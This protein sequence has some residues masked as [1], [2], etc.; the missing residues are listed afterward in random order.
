[1]VKIF[2]DIDAVFSA[3][4]ESGT[5][6]SLYAGPDNDHVSALAAE[7]IA[8]EWRA[9]QCLFEAQNAENNPR[10]DE[11]TEKYFEETRKI[12]AFASAV[13]ANVAR[14]LSSG[15]FRRL[16]AFSAFYMLC[17]EPE[18]EML[19]AVCG[20]I[21]K[22]VRALAFDGGL[23]ANFGA[24]GADGFLAEKFPGYPPAS[25]ETVYRKGGELY[26]ET[27]DILWKK[28]E[29]VFAA[30]EAA[31]L[32]VF[33][34]CY[35]AIISMSDKLTVIYSSR[36]F[37]VTLKGSTA[38]CFRVSFR[39]VS[40]VILKTSRKYSK[41]RAWLELWRTNRYSIDFGG[42]EMCGAVYE[43][44]EIYSGSEIG[45][46]ILPAAGTPAAATLFQEL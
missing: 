27:L 31:E 18:K 13:S 1:M 11:W 19:A 9:A 17:Q 16:E 8:S 3:I 46:A 41:V 28:G 35:N 24:G 43:D 36:P 25:P 2:E 10:R 15:N 6:S 40:G 44:R 14:S 21:I 5:G 7:L 30:G 20:S 34:E 22:R 37:D 45:A 38:R 42:W 26:R 32:E 23:Q 4:S 33:E 12:N 39:T 29:R